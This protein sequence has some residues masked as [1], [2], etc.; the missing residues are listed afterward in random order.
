MKRKLLCL[1]TALTISTG[2]HATK[3]EFSWNAEYGFN[4]GNNVVTGTFEGTTN[5]NLITDLSNISV[6]INGIAFN[7]NGNLY[8]LSYDT[9][10]ATGWV[11]GGA[12]ASFNG[13]ENNFL[14]INADYPNSYDYTNY[15][16][17]SFNVGGS[18]AYDF[19]DWN[20]YAYTF[21]STTPDNWSVSP[22]SVPEPTPLLLLALGLLGLTRFRQPK[23]A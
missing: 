3:F 13:T 4:A 16:Y 17:S 18:Q 8:G 2:A 1:A 12:Q 5:G 14:F 15:F 22:V 21:G 20:N 23:G 11:S 10:S 6:F 19:N 7:G 9:N